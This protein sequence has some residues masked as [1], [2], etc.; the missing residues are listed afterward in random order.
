MAKYR[1]KPGLQH[2]KGGRAI[3]PGQV[4]ELSPNEAKAFG[5]KFEFVEGD[6]EFKPLAEI[7][8]EHGHQSHLQ[9]HHKGGGWYDVINTLSGQKINDRALS[10]EDADSL[11]EEG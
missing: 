2:Q 3:R 10:S 9:K 4:V 8:E 5:D 6:D 1:L 11:L 7:E